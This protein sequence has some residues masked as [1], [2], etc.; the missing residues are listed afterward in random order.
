VP[1]YGISGAD[2]K[3][4]LLWRNARA[5]ARGDPWLW[6]I[7]KRDQWAKA[8]RGADG[9]FFPWGNRFDV[10][11]IGT[12]Q[13]FEKDRPCRSEPRDESPFGV[14]DLGG[15]CREWVEAGTALRGG[16]WGGGDPRFYRA[17]YEDWTGEGYVNHTCGFRP[18]L[19]PRG[20]PR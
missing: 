4:F 15:S 9:R 13:V 18:I 17:S 12:Q 8:A 5:E 7:P 3:D 10:V 6:A 1:V 20:S 11:F 19:V 14:A 2:V 16:S